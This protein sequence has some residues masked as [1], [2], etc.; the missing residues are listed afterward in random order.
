MMISATGC[1]EMSV[2]LDS[3]LSPTERGEDALFRVIPMPLERTVSYG[4]GTAQGPAAIL[5]ASDEL[6]RLCQGFEPC[7]Q[8]IFTE[9]A[10]ACDGDLPDCGNAKCSESG[11]ICGGGD[12]N[13]ISCNS[14]YS[15]FDPKQRVNMSEQAPRRS[16]VELAIIALLLCVLSL[17]FFV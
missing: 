8:G 13:C 1:R 15:V 12:S 4:A 3:E 10:V 5:Q 9:P 6:E 16:F 7:A 11:W 14:F 2:F 17:N